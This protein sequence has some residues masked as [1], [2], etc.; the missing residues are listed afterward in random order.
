MARLPVHL[1]A[2]LF[3]LA[4]A[5][6]LPAQPTAGTDPAHTGGTPEAGTAPRSE[7]GGS[8]WQR[9]AAARQADAP[10]PTGVTST[11]EAVIQSAGFLYF[12]PD[13]RFRNLGM[14][15]Y[16]DGFENDALTYFKRAAHYAD[17]A[18]QAMVAEMYLKGIG[19]APDPARAYAWMD[20]AAERG[21]PAFVA[22][23]EH[24]WSLLDAA[25]RERALELGLPLF[26]RYQDTV[27]K[28]RLEGQLRRGR[29]QMTGSRVGFRGALQITMAGPNGLPITVTGDQYYAD[30][31]WRPE[32]YWAWQDEIWQAP[33]RGRVDVLPLRRVDEDEARRD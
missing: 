12:H 2:G 32:A 8:R 13:I 20:L 4:L 29:R 10:R 18:S 5:A 31:F 17:K 26:E 27:A 23:R 28:P 3:V 25:Q 19:T 30:R 24:Y 33:L 16:D 9:R 6:P 11:E 14:K 1:S 15:A 21:Y 22:L 7:R